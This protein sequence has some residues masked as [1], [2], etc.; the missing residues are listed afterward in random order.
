MPKDVVNLPFP[1]IWINAYI[2]AV[3]NEYGFSVLT[4][5]SNQAAIDDLSKNRVD[6]PTQY[7]DEPP[8]PVLA[9]I[10]VNE[11][12]SIGLSTL[13]YLNVSLIKGFFISSIVSDNSYFEYVQRYFFDKIE[14][15][16]LIAK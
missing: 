12:N 10:S 8:S 15:L 6:I 16:N 1:P 5:P 14:G 2:Q 7:D 13:K 11:N 4:I 3:L 9:G